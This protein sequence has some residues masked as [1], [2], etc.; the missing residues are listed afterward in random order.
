VSDSTERRFLHS[1]VAAY[2]SL[3]V[4]MLVTFVSRLILARLVLPVDHGLYELALRIVMV[5]AAVRDLGLPYHLMRDRRRPYGTVL[6][7]VL[8]TGV[9]IATALF[10]VAPATS[11]LDLRLPAV[12]RVLAPWVLLDALVVVPRTFFDR[13]LRI[14]R[15]VGAEIARGLTVAAISVGLAARGWGVWSF[16]A[17]ELL[18]AAVFA[19]LVWRRAWGEMPIEVKPKLIPDLLHQSR[20]LFAIWIVFILVTY[21]DVYIVEIFTDTQ[22]VGFY[23]RAYEIAFLVSLI[24]AP[25]ALLP[26]LVEYRDDPPRFLTAFRIGTVLVL[27]FQVMGGYFLFFN[28]ERVV[29][30]LLGER[31]APAVPLLKVLC[32][33]PFINVFT[34]LGG[35]VLKVKHEDRAWLAVVALNL[36][37][38]ASFGV[39]FASRWGAVGMAWANFLLLGEAVLAW[40][41]AVIFRGGFA[42]LVRDLLVVYLVPLP[43]FAAAAGLFAAGSWGRFGASWAA[44]LLAMGALSLRF[45]RPFRSFFAARPLGGDAGGEVT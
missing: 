31:W 36:A 35:E 12:L 9:V 23:S 45:Y 15:L 2:G 40:R 10:L 11:V 21:I 8:G 18:A 32:F 33:V 43:F 26:A 3:S 37:A 29:S 17:G 13:E 30:I 4:R 19:A 27:A 38:L 39:F 7:F 5:A 28:A 6:A 24:V 22:T 41:M 44:F 20:Y 1:T 25:R 16:V 34:N 14:G 42:L